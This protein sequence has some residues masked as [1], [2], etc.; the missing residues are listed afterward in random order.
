MAKAAAKNVMTPVL[1]VAL[2]PAP[3]TTTGAG[4][5]DDDG[6]ELTE[7]VTAGFKVCAPLDTDPAFVP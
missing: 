5:P 1:P 2:L 6:V 7:G 3:V 4:F